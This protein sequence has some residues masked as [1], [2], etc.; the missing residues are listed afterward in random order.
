[1]SHKPLKLMIPAITLLFAGASH[2]QQPAGE[3]TQQAKHEHGAVTLNLAIEG[4]S[5]AVEL[6]A[7]A[8]NVVGFERAPRTAD[9]R[10]AMSA[11]AA[12]LFSGA[13][14]IGVPKAAG[15]RRDSASLEVPDWAKSTSSRDHAHDHDH[16]HDHGHDSG[17]DHADYRASI[18]YTCS[19]PAALAWVEVWGLRKLRDVSAMTVNIVTTASQKSVSTAK[20][21]ERIALR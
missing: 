14:M 12:W 10:A 18:R 21:D 11:A 2:A 8:I 17:E 3:F 20:P 9:E 4:N 13:G 19:D 5:L 16:D 6:E 15:C 1:M 7:P